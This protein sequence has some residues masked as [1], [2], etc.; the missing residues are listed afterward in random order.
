MKLVIIKC[1]LIWP[2]F[3][4][5]RQE[6]SPQRILVSFY[7]WLDLPC[8]LY[9]MAYIA[10]LLWYGSVYSGSMRISHSCSEL[11]FSNL[12]QQTR[13]TAT[14]SLKSVTVYKLGRFA[15]TFHLSM[16]IMRFKIYDSKITVP[17]ASAGSGLLCASCQT[18]PRS[19]LGSPESSIFW[20]ITTCCPLKVNRHFGETCRLHLQG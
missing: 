18:Q 5:V 6:R 7:P 15:T 11:S 17:Q 9:I 3:P 8:L 14:V 2:Y 19:V 1:P 16:S 10:Y 12:Q 13:N 4:H 20:N